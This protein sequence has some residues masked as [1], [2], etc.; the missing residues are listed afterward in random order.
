MSVLELEKLFHKGPCHSRREKQVIERNRRA[1]LNS[2][3]E[4]TNREISVTFY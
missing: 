4:A 3:S 2:A 1:K